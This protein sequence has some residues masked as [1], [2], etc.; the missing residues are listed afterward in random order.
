MGGK[1]GRGGGV[2]RIAPVAMAIGVC[3]LSGCS[4]LGKAHDETAGQLTPIG[5]EFDRSRH[6]V[7]TVAE[8]APRSDIAI[9]PPSVEHVVWVRGEG[10]R[11]GRWSEVEEHTERTPPREAQP[12]ESTDRPAK[13]PDDEYPLLRDHGA[14]ETE[15]GR[16]PMCLENGVL[17]PC[18]DAHLYD[19]YGSKG[20]GYCL[21]RG[22]GR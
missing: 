5:G 16:V 6:G 1:S 8:V 9:L 12:A 10:T 19:C 13:T 22:A 17:E 2:N 7:I 3:V 11:N 4:V 18:E 20:G 15:Y 14:Y 21:E